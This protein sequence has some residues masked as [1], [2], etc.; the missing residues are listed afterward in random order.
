MS[1]LLDTNVVSEIVRKKPD[2]N[3]TRWVESVPDAALHLSVISLGEIRHG[4]EAVR[5]DARKERLRVWLE[6]DLVI[7]SGVASSRSPRPSP[8]DGAGFW[9]KRDGR[10]RLSTAC[11][12]LRPSTTISAS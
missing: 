3:V 6:H 8:T 1:Y 9:P 2:A 11:S 10:C 12:P 5:N 4:V 7:G